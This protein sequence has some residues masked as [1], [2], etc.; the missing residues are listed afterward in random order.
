[1]SKQ[2][3]YEKMH[4]YE[5]AYRISAIITYIAAAVTVISCI[6]T[7]PGMDTSGSQPLLI[8]YSCIYAAYTIMLFVCALLAFLYFKNTRKEYA[9]VQ[10]L[11]LFLAGAF[12]LAN[13][14]MFIVLF[15]YGAGMD[16]T[17]EKVFGTNMDE[18]TQSFTAGWIMLA[19]GFAIIML[20]GMLSI[21]R[22][23]AKRYS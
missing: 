14:K 18:L 5:K 15:L 7:V 16:S 9:A 13:V 23:A 22:M 3:R 4:K 17:V 20:L 21:V 6:F 12:T 11:M 8:V 19:V 2:I 1:M 10:S